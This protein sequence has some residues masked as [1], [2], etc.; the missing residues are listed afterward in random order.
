MEINK[1]SIGQ[2]NCN[3]TTKNNQSSIHL[4]YNVSTAQ[5]PGTI[6]V[7]FTNFS[8]QRLLTFDAMTGLCGEQCGADTDCVHHHGHGDARDL[9]P[10]LCPADC[11]NNVDVAV[12]VSR[13][14]MLENVVDNIVIL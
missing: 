5:T 8:R 14:L 7:Q 12:A 9:L 3:L 1:S 4:F 13:N 11:S 10:V 6:V 2:A